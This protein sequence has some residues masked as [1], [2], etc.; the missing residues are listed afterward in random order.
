MHQI[1]SHRC[2]TSGPEDKKGGHQIRGRLPDL[3]FV[4]PV[5]PGGCHHYRTGKNHTGYCIV[6]LT[7]QIHPKK[8]VIIIALLI[9]IA[10]PALLFALGSAPARSLLKDSLSLLTILAFSFM[11]QQLFLTRNFKGI[12]AYYKLSQLSNIHKYIGY[13]VVTVFLFHPVLLVVPRFFEAG[14]KPLDALITLLTTFQSLGVVLGLIAWGLMLLLGMT[15]IFR[16][17]LVQKLGIKYKAWRL[18]HGALS[19]L[20]ISIASWHAIE[21]GRHVDT[22]MAS[23]IMVFAVSGAVLLV[24]QYVLTTEK[25]T[26]VT[27]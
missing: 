21:L 4:P 19:V 2:H 26:G 7:M 17:K 25:R 10:L 9:F 12:Q 6:G 23:F 8:I 1:L 18:F 20:F 16:Y 22:L 13:F 5:L 15:A 14:V 27:S 24:K 3:S 11:L